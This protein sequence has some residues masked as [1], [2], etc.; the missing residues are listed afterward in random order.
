MTNSEKYVLTSIVSPM[1]RIFDD[2]IPA[3]SLKNL[4]GM[5]NEPLAFSVAYRSMAQKAEN[6]RAPDTP[7]SI[8]V[9]SDIPAT[10]YK[11]TKTS[12]AAAEC[13]DAK[14]GTPGGCPDILK[15]RISAPSIVK[16]P[17]D[18]KLPYI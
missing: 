15:E 9:I 1:D 7:I 14:E 6:R 3:E 4:G 11:V 10:A 8:R 12:Y 2:F 16:L 18:T 5:K 17:L 13:E